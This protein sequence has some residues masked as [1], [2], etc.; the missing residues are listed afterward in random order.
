V[1]DGE[2][3]SP[4][5]QALAQA[6]ALRCALELALDVGSDPGGALRALAEALPAGQP[7][8]RVIVFGA[9]L[10]VTTP[11]ALDAVREELYGF[12][13]DLGPLVSG[14][15]LDLYQVHLFDPPRADATCWGMHPQA[16]ATDATS[17]AETP[18]AAGHQLRTLRIRRPGPIAI[19]VVRLHKVLADPRQVSLLGAAW[20]LAVLAEL[21]AQGA[22]SITIYDTIG[23]RGVMAED[24]V[25]PLFHVIA[26]VAELAAGPGT[27]ILRPAEGVTGLLTRRAVLLANL[28][29]EP[30]TV[31]LPDGCRPASIRLLDA[32]SARSAMTAPD[33]FRA[34]TT[35]ASDASVVTLPP[36]ATARLDL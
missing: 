5:R 33:T 10:F 23:P 11:A 30:R 14:S 35:K 24:V 31:T 9:G 16:H 6:T 7:V 25:F 3:Q 18:V 17:I 19:S 8:A 1:L 13:P 28:S 32:A 22:D 20:T 27:D 21:V 15:R 26:D 34:H 2:W 36:F 12:R 4:L 29:R